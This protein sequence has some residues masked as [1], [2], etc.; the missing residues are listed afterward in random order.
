[1]VERVILVHGD[2]GGAV[3]G[4]RD[5]TRMLAAQLAR[6]PL[7]VAELRLRTAG[8]AST[9]SLRFLRR[10]RGAG[11][12][13]A[14]VI[15]YSP[16]CFGRRGFAPWLP[17][18]LLALRAG[19][20][21]PTVALMVHESYVPMLS[22]RWTLM[23]LWQRLQL[24]AVRLVSD[25]VLTSIEPWQRE[26]EA[27]PPGGQVGH[28]PV[29]SNFP[30]ARARRRAEREALGAGE[31][32]VV[33][34]CLGRDHPAWLG[35]YVVEAVNAIAAAGRPVALLELG[36]EAP[37]L[38]GID[39]AVAV[40]APG[41]LEP[42]AFAAKLSASDLFL[43]PLLDGAST[44]RGSLMAALQHGLPIVA[45]AGHLTDPLLRR[46]PAALRLTEVGDRERFAAAAAE[47]VADPGARA[48]AGEAA[49]RLYEREFDW[50]VIADKLLGSLPQR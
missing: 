17:L 28:L 41:M 13:A 47:L 33:V 39:P 22:W 21:R 29:G 24:V 40:H 31:D 3:D 32:T 49:R 18:S 12:S 15:Q 11:A 35:E 14:V 19:G 38:E 48:G 20:R 7:A 45:T 44:R 8:A 2:R 10:L 34:S 50:A 30:D 23:G 5:H 1:M 16:F 26:L 25:V 42:E 4:I 43:L 9:E 46:E 27:Q 36:A 37:P 6:R